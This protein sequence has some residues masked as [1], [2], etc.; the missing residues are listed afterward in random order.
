M[1]VPQETRATPR[2][3]AFVWEILPHVSRTF[4]LTIPALRAP[5]RDWV[6]TAYVLCRIADTVEDAEG[7]PP[8]RR[9]ELFALL[10]HLAAN[11]GDLTSRRRFLT[12]WPGGT[13]AE[14]ER[15]M[16]EAGTVFDALLALPAEP[17]TAVAA[18]LEE[19]S[20]GMALFASSEGEERPRFVCPDL[21]AL[22]AYCHVAAGT[23]GILLSRLFALEIGE[24]WLTA[25]RVESGRRFGLGLQLTNV[26][27]DRDQD[28]RR[29]VSYV[30]PS[31]VVGA[32]GEFRLSPEGVRV[33]TLRA[34]EHLDAGNDY[35]IS[36]PAQRPDLRLFCLWASHLALATLRLLAGAGGFG[37]KVSREEVA[38]I[39][40]RTR[41]AAA[42]DAGL[43]AMH[44]EARS[45]VVAALPDAAG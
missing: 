41:E 17:R 19:M 34:L 10:R 24:G 7:I 13:D 44:A 26:L 23:V 31:L 11:P 6:A 27:K 22:E 25:E 20:V 14:H 39:L 3:L 33:L 29:G 5:L 1:P 32:A 8:P 2:S 42:D 43:I 28:R 38:V 4:A 15:L 45:A 9:L 36:L 12:A 35:V 37:A 18:C 40:E 30:P 16:Q 21:P